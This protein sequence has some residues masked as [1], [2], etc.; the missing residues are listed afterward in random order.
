MNQFYGY[1]RV[2]TA[3][4]G[5][6][7][8]LPQ[9]R[10]AIEQYA[11]RHGYEIAQW[12]EEQETA[13]K[14]GRPVFGEMIK[15]LG[16]GNAR[17][18]IIH[19]IDRSARNLR[20]WADLGE[21]ID[22]GVEVHFA[23]EALNL[24]SRGGRLSADIQAVVAADYIRNLREE[25]KKGFWGRLK[26]GL[27]PMPAPVGYVNN[28]AGKPKTLDP[29]TAPLVRKA[30]ELYGTG[31]YNLNSLC[32]ELSR[33]GLRRKT[34]TSIQPNRLS[35]ILNNPFYM[36]LIHIATSNETFRG[37]HEPLVS[38][39]LF[40]R[41]QT[42]LQ[43]KLNTRTIKHDFLFRRRLTCKNCGYS[44]IGERQK[45]HVYY[46]CQGRGC[47]TTSI[48][49]E[50]VEEAVLKQL[51]LLRFSSGEH[52][53]FRRKLADMKIHDAD[54]REKLSEALRLQI[55]QI[56]DRLNRLTDAYIDRLIEKE[57]FEQRKGALLAERTEL[58][59]RFA[60]C[61]GGK[62]SPSGALENF[63][64]RADSAYLAYKRGLPE[65][66]RDLLDSLTSNRAV[67]GKTPEIMLAFPFNEVAN[68]IESSD[69]S[70]GRDIHRTSARLLSRILNALE[71]RGKRLVEEKMAA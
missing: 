54:E 33:L 32:R 6:G 23:N 4:Q 58:E 59:Q 60:E 11:Q 37:A 18:V 21:L 66:K 30:F 67:S 29:K 42:I 62:V 53:W 41:V 43:G 25:T 8:S 61:R 57:L 56:E 12:F 1:I 17:G 71:R 13:A 20:D 26:Q 68:R 27:F 65:E 38:R 48:R 45:G 64:E 16:R 44:L 51:S 15:H 46:R 24:H 31:R 49:E 52:R 28:G 50:E 47:P 19:K 3:R 35:R 14:S 34:G 22:G 39:R 69:G 63:L 9:Q 70:P 10:A 7:V 2:S 40:D 36:G 5:D 55:V